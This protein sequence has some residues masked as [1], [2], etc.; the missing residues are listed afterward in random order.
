M[1]KQNFFYCIFFLIALAQ[2]G[3]IEPLIASY[4]DIANAKYATKFTMTISLENGMPEKGL[5]AIKLPVEI[6]AK[7]DKVYWRQYT[8]PLSTTWQVSTIE[9]STSTTHK[10][11]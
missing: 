8:Q 2:A 9:P 1:K 11:V 7:V 6:F 5:L 4:W 10:Y 3:Y